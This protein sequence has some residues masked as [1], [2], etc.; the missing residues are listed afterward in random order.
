MSAARIGASPWMLSIQIVPG[1]SLIALMRLVFE[2][3]ALF[4]AGSSI[5]PGFRRH[6]DASYAGGGN[7]PFQG[8]DHSLLSQ[9][10]LIIAGVNR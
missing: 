7:L 4:G 9:I 8:H 3:S 2:V 1:F 5:R 10:A 6:S